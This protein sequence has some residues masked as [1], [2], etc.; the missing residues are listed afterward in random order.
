MRVAA[1]VAL[2]LTAAGC[3]AREAGPSAGERGE[4]FYWW[5]ES[6]TAP[7]WGD[8]TDDP[9]LRATSAAYDDIDGTYVFYRV[10][11]D[12]ATA[13]AMDCETTAA[14]TC[15][16]RD[17][18]LVM[19]VDGHHL[20]GEGLISETEFTGADCTQM[21]WLGQDLTDQ[22]DALA[23]TFTTRFELD[24]P[25]CVAVDDQLAAASSN[26]M[27]VDGCTLAVEGVAVYEASRRQ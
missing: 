17:P 6:H 21:A 7:V 14:S 22:G 24:G 26:G 9:D 20:V 3:G 15:D 11:D 8:C 19:T 23:F 5:I 1:M 10:S 13:E 25:D 2:A 16:P 12:G 4:V 27:G 18:P